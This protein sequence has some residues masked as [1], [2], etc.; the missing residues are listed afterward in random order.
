MRACRYIFFLLVLLVA[1]QK[2]PD[3]QETD[4]H[5]FTQEELQKKKVDD[6]FTLFFEAFKLDE[7]QNPRLEIIRNSHVS[8]PKLGTIRYTY[9]KD[10]VTL[11]S[12]DVR[13]GT[14]SADLY[15]GIHVEGQSLDGE[16]AAVYID[17]ERTATV[18][19]IWY[20][21]KENG[22][23]TRKLTPVFLFDDGTTYAVN[24]VLLVEPLIDYLLKNVFKTE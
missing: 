15:G 1:C 19:L 8:I 12:M 7:V 17:G 4:M 11:L 10:G 13:G 6:S 20:E 18:E 16:G 3:V 24:S 14:L 2:Q 21:Y 22:E 9:V 23:T 5:E